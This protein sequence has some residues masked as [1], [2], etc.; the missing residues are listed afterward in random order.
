MYWTNY[1]FKVGINILEL[2]K[3][4]NTIVKQIATKQEN[5]YYTTICSKSKANVLELC[6]HNDINELT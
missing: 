2:W 1:L 3:K 4:D 6:K 5:K